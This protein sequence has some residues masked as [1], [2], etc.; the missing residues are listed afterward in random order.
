MNNGTLDQERVHQ[1]VEI[2]MGEEIGQNFEEDN[3]QNIR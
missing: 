1:E 2:E 3:E